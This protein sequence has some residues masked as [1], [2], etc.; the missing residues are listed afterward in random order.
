M[1]KKI[2]NEENQAKNLELLPFLAQVNKEKGLNQQQ[3]ALS[4]ANFG[5]NKLPKSIEKGLF[6]RI[7]KQL[8]EPLTLVLIFV[9]IISVII[10]IIFDDNQPFW[11]KII[12]YL[13]PVVVAVIIAINVFFSLVQ[14]EKS[15]KA[16]EA[17]SNLN[18]PV[19][20]IIRN[21]QKISLDSRDILV[22]DIL[23]VSAGDLIS[24]DGYVIEMK[25]FSVSEAILTGESI[26]VYKE[27]TQSW[28]NEAS[29]VFSGSSV[30][31]GSAKILVSSVGKRTKLG[32]IALLVSKTEELESPL[33][34][35]IAKFSKIITFIAA[36]LAIAFFFIYIYLVASGDFSHFKEAIVIALSLA[37]GFVPEGL[38]PLVTINLIIGVK[39]LAKN[40]AIVKDLKT[41]ETLGAVS[42][43][44]SDKT[45]T[46]TENK[47][48]IVDVFYHQTKEEDFWNQAVLNTS[49]YSFL[50]SET[51]KFFGDPE[52]VLI[53]KKAKNYKIEK[54]NLEK[55]YKFID[56]IPFSSKLK[57]SATFYQIENKKILFIKGAPEIIF[58][59]AKNID[60]NLKEKLNVLQKFGYRI[61]AFGFSEIQGT[62]NLDKNLEKYLENI[63]ISGL[64][65]FQDPPRKEIGPIVESLFRAKIQTIMITGDSFST[66]KAV[67]N[68]V[69]IL[70]KN[71]LFIDRVDWRK[72]D[73]WKENIEKFHLYTRSQPEDKLEIVNA[74]QAKKHVVAMLGDGVN[75]APSLKKA[76]VGFAM[77][78]TGSQVSKQV[79][80]V[81]LVDDNF[82]S[83]YSAI[84]TGRNIVTN[85]K[86]L[87]VF[88]LAANF[89]MLFSVIFATL[90]FKEQIFSSLQILWINVVSETFG[91]I[92]LGLT[93][94]KKNVMN[95]D[96]LQENQQLF[97]K[98]IVVKIVFWAILNTF[99]ALFSFWLSTS[100]TISFLI[101][102]LSLASLSYILTTN[103]L[104]FRYKLVD[105]KFLHIGFLASFFSVLFVSLVPGI[106][107][108]FSPKD[109]LSSYL[110]ILENS[111]Y[112]ILF[113]LVLGPIFIDQI[114][115]IFA[116]SRK[117]H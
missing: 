39:K 89:S 111:N 34:K 48:K 52:E 9:I 96:F 64:I 88:L 19:S 57:F 2:I 60:K 77:G 46:I 47:M 101:I 44:C 69:G 75:D 65:A 97:S 10:T 91:G 93:N 63:S 28:D 100:S 62:E 40:N 98:K 81:V 94:I 31:S 54:H 41:I 76:D 84:K 80:N 32:K 36:F 78:I 38:V 3:I 104:L 83:L 18:A 113:L 16:I 109:F 105:L 87:F 37:I 1:A 30:L 24:G 13:E 29:Q 20:T 73:F 21:G 5:E 7:L 58:Q 23:E 61:F 115:K 102:S 82:Q 27:K 45:G 4:L 99:L 12:S 103:D 110:L 107:V 108:I 17:I 70:K 51:E 15:K 79:A 85:I 92:A 49:A 112:Y 90:I 22:G 59:K 53:L 11:S 116:N 86:Q 8:K 56:K 50:D 35:K 33:Q 72:D 6:F 55:T 25:D 42:I 14:E 67:A 71:S 26:S 68:S 106:N 114:W 66:G 95:E 117:K 43:I 74:L